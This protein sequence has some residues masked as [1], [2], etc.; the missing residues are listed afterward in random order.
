ME[1]DSVANK[2]VTNVEE[3]EEDLYLK[4]KELQNKLELIEI[5]EDYIK[6][7]LNHLKSEEARSKEEVSITY[8]FLSIWRMRKG[9]SDLTAMMM[10]KFQGKIFVL[11]KFLCF[12]LDLKN[13]ERAYAHR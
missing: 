12:S 6:N 9:S 5:Q 8:N 13:S 2:P 10:I 7:E 1:V 3:E 11:T 4:M